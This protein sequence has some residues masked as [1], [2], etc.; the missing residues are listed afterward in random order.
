M[1]YLTIILAVWAIGATVAVLFVRGA[2]LREQ[3]AAA[4]QEREAHLGLASKNIR[5]TV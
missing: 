5:R 4:A 3:L 1:N 2:A